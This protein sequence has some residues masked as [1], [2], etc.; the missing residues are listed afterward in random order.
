MRAGSESPA[1]YFDY[2]S[3]CSIGDGFEDVLGKEAA[4]L[5]GARNFAPEEVEVF[6]IMHV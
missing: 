3:G 6:A 5:T 1:D 2:A 4:S